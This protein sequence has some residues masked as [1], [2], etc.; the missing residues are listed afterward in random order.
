M[1]NINTKKVKYIESLWSFITFSIFLTLSMIL[2]SCSKSQEGPTEGSSQLTIQI[3]GINNPTN[4][5]GKMAS[6]DI[7]NNIQDDFLNVSHKETIKENDFII[8]VIS[9]Q[10]NIDIQINDNGAINNNLNT[11]RQKI[12]TTS[13]MGSGIKYRILLYNKDTGK[14]AT[15]I[16]ATAGQ[17]LTIDVVKGQRFKWYAYSYNSVDDIINPD[18][19]NPTL[20]TPT[21]KPLLYASG[22]IT[23]ILGNN[24]LPITFSHKLTQLNVNVHSRNYF[25][26]I[27]SING[28]F[29]D[30]YVKT[31]TFNLLTGQKEGSL[32]PV[33]ISS[34]SFINDDEGSIRE[35]V[36]SYY[37]ADDNMSEYSVRLTQLDIQ[38]PN[39]TTVNLM[40]KLPN[41]GV[42][43]FDN[44]TTSN[45]GNVL[46]GQLRLWLVLP[47]KTI[48]HYGTSSAIR[49]YEAQSGSHSGYFLR[50]TRNFGPNS[51]YFKIQGFDHIEVK[52]ASGNM[53][54]ALANP[55]NYPDVIICGMFSHMN[56]S[57]YTAVERYVK[58]GGSIFLMSESSDSD[59]TNFFKS[60]FNNNQ[61]T[62]KN[63]DGSGAVYKL[64]NGDPDVTDGPFGDIRGH[65]WGQDRSSTQYTFNLNLNDIILYTAE[66]VN[67]RRPS[68]NNAA[69][70]FRHKNLNLFFIGD[71][72]FLASEQ[73]NLGGS[74]RSNTGYPFATVGGN[75]VNKYFPTSRSYG[76][77]SSS[78]SSES[79]PNGGW[80]VSNSIIFGNALAWILERAH[81]DP[82][83]RN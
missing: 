7:N 18:E 79:K 59:L 42:V 82:V 73:R 36:A 60:V 55:S 51:N 23:P 70:M 68:G 63:E 57:D 43:K 54:R 16:V 53:A 4:S 45:S 33:N 14:R 12:A 37:T 11:I 1:N 77:A 62:L 2:Y 20:T 32:T 64:I 38:H 49:G 15:S 13:K 5:Q 17:S 40:P 66:S 61:I 58:K 76:R 22:E 80:Q 41:G 8:D 48:L 31:S 3:S 81:F 26:D 35:K 39:N 69:T 19:T 30:N 83:Q 27:V 21:D 78:G 56:A 72:G 47:R 10:E 65:Y 28:E 46:K 52:S 29:V 6:L 44:F 50:E 74:D 25:G 34:L 75:A 9:E 67:F 71:T 24:P